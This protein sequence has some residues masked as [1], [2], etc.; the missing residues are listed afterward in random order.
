MP[1]LTSVDREKREI[2]CVAVGPVTYDDVQSH[3]LRE[4]HWGALPYR[5]L[6]DGRGAGPQFTAEDVRRIV[7]L[8]RTLSRE[9]K[10]GRTA[11][12]VSTDYA[13]GLM[14]MLE[15]MVDDVCQIRV[16]REEGEARAWLHAMPTANSAK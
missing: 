6:I 9:S 2:R 7:D 8:L 5:E 12:V 13:F 11:I 10:L 3:L 14:H 15:L 16:F 1:I 4:K